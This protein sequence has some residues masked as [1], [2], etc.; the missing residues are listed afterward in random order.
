ME[1]ESNK[2]GLWERITIATAILGA[3]VGLFKEGPIAALIKFVFILVF[4]IA[5]KTLVIWVFTDSD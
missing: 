4:M 5:L 3:I 2:L 1:D